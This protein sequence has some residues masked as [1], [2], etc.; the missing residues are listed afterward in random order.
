MFP[1]TRIDPC[2]LGLDE[3]GLPL[4]ASEKLNSLPDAFGVSQS[5]GERI[6]LIVSRL[7]ASERYKG[8]DQLI[9]IMPSLLKQVPDA[10]LIIVGSGND[11]ERLKS[12]ARKSGAGAAILFTGFASPG[13]LAALYSRCRLFAMPSRGEGFGLVYLEAMRFAKPCVASRLDAGAEVV[14]DGCTGLLVDPADA[15][16]LSSAVARFLRDEVLATQLGQAGFARLNQRYRFQH[17]RARLQEKLSR[18][19]PELVR[20]G[21]AGW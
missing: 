20:G 7:S 17:Y 8:H 1:G 2:E 16:E 4:E 10:Q 3:L 6:V 21:A 14:A 5:L 19:I 15:E 11:A 18:V 9:A 13:L 12:A